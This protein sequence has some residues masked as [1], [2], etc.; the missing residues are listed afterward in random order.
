MRKWLVVILILGLISPFVLLSAY[1]VYFG[2]DVV[3]GNVALVRHQIGRAYFPTGEPLV[4]A[5]MLTV[6]QFPTTWNGDLANE[7]LMEASGISASRVSSDVYFSV[8]DSGNPPQLFA[9]GSDG[10]DLA[11]WPIAYHEHHDFED[12]SGFRFNR[13]N[14]LLIADTGDNFYWRPY[15]TLLVI[16]EPDLT[17]ADRASLKPVWSFNVRYPKGARD[18]EA[19]A[20]DVESEKILLISK[21]R[22]PAEVFEVPLKPGVSEVTARKVAALTGIPEPS[23]RDLREDPGWGKSKSL[24]TAFDI[25]GRHAV[26]ITYKDAYIY[27]RRRRESWADALS[28]LPVRIL[29]PHIN[30]L[31]S[32]GF[33]HSGDSL[34][35]TGERHEGIARMGLFE[36]K[37][38]L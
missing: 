34:V 24:P 2:Y 30:G 22:I 21:R 6:K 7:T 38:D 28:G 10:S 9:V 12:I 15:V 29:L 27:E 18:V 23:A 4:E 5:G 8:N 3:S 20:V 33:S 36:V 14:Y 32:G 31:E 13:K 26:V 1:G 17:S 35:V 19:V 37:L 25:F 11:T 16:E